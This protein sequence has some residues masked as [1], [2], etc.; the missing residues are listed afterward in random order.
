MKR[1][2][3]AALLLFLLLAPLACATAAE[4]GQE[5]TGRVYV[6]VEN[7]ARADLSVSIYSGGQELRLGRV[8]VGDDQ[9]FYVPA[10]VLRSAPYS[11]AV[12]LIARDGSG[13]YTTPALVV[14]QGQN[15]HI[16]ASPTLS[17]SRF[18][19]R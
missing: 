18:T 12:R 2:S 10:P 17:S 19:V 6:Q 16:D 4:D 5:A 14:N 1:L 8:Q 7:S 13:E 15:V 11:F 3:R 9:R